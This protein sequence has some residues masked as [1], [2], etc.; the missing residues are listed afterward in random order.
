MTGRLRHSS[1][2][3]AGHKAGIVSR[4]QG[5]TRARALRPNEDMSS[6]AL[7]RLA[8]WLAD[9]SAEAAV[10]GAEQDT[11]SPAAWR[12]PSAAVVPVKTTRARPT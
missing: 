5:G 8:V 7:V 11:S 10:S 2:S 9:V 12:R 4:P 6:S 1:T 3:A